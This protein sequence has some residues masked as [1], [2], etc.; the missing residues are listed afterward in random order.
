ME[1]RCYFA[2]ALCVCIVAVSATAENAPDPS[3][4]L[5]EA[6][7][8]T[9]KLEDRVK[10]YN[11]VARKHKKLKS[12]IAKEKATKANKAIRYMENYNAKKQDL[13]REQAKLEA[14][15]ATDRQGILST[16]P[17]V[18]KKYERNRKHDTKL[19]RAMKSAMHSMKSVETLTAHKAKL[20]PT[21]AMAQAAATK[22]RGS[23]VYTVLGLDEKQLSKDYLLDLDAAVAAYDAQPSTSAHEKLQKAMKKAKE[24]MQKEALKE[25]KSKS[26]KHAKKSRGR[27]NKKYF[28]QKWKEKRKENG[29]K[30]DRKNKFVKKIKAEN[31]SKTFQRDRISKEADAKKLKGRAEKQS[32]KNAYAAKHKAW[33]NSAAGKAHLREKGIKKFETKKKKLNDKAAAAKRDYRKKVIWAKQAKAKLNNAKSELKAGT[34]NVGAVKKQV[35]AAKQALATATSNAASQKSAAN[36]KIKNSATKFLA[37]KVATL[38]KATT[39]VTRKKTLVKERTAKVSKSASNRNLAQKKMLA[40]Y[41]ESKMYGAKGRTKFKMARRRRRL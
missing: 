15:I 22:A 9:S 33:A 13:A 6:R 3:D 12:K 31:G 27:K 21:V 20:D 18:A 25:R 19:K 40:L 32:K 38:L 17:K 14:R 37:A 11:D 24:K 34:T 8:A 1:A 35:A 5:M 41:K 23:D 7:G 36:I 10:A 16:T 26:E 28:K 4:D 2:L 39:G 29:K 30:T